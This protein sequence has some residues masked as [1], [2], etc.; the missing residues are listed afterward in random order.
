MVVSEYQAQKHFRNDAAAKRLASGTIER[1]CLAET[2]HNTKIQPVEKAKPSFC[3]EVET[4]FPRSAVRE[5]DPALRTEKAP[6][7]FTTD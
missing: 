6:R 2:N 4:S 1:A 7:R 5:L 3:Y